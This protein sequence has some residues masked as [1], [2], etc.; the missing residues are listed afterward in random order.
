MSDEEKKAFYA[1]GKDWIQTKSGRKFWPLSPRSEDIRLSDIAHALSMTTRF[2]GHLDRFY[3]VAEHSRLVALAT[4]HLGGDE[5][6]YK[7]A[8]LHDASEA[9]LCDIASPVKQSPEFAG[10]RAAEDRLQRAIYRRYQ[11]Q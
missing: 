8:L 6:D 3:S 7:Q 1:P 9:Y 4:R 2:T 10:Y 5:E 11:V